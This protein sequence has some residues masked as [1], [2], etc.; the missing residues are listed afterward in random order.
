MSRAQA[1]LRRRRCRG[2]RRVLRRRRCRGRRRVLRRRRGRGCRWFCGRWA[3]GTGGTAAGLGGVSGGGSGGRAGASGG[4]AGASGGVA[5]GGGAAAGAAG[6]AAT[7]CPAVSATIST[8]KASYKDTESTFVTFSGLRGDNNDLLTLAYESGTAGTWIMSYLP[9]EPGTNR[10]LTAGSWMFATLRGHVRHPLPDPGQTICARSAPFTVFTPTPT[11]VSTG[12][13]S[14]V[15]G[16]AMTVTWMRLPN[17]P[18]TGS[19]IAMPGS[20]IDQFVDFGAVNEAERYKQPFLQGARGR[21]IRAP[22]DRSVHAAGREP[23]LRG[24]P[25]TRDHPDDF[26]QQVELPVRGDNHDYLY[27]SAGLRPGPDRTGAGKRRRRH[28]PRPRAHERPSGTATITAPNFAGSYV[29]RVH[30]NGTTVVSARS[31]AFTVA[32]AP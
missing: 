32:G 24:H 5:G 22:C 14:Y 20:P 3:A 29:V 11:T 10:N 30:V 27:G 4:S 16:K 25:E 18:P 15:S 19:Y 13:S 17:W 21:H 8:D 31:A 2:R 26:D 23:A 1:V 6:T 7:G 9:R 28:L 12:K